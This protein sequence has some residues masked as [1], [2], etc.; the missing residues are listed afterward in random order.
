MNTLFDILPEEIIN[1]IYK[2]VN[3]D[4]LYKVY[5]LPNTERLEINYSENEMIN[6]IENIPIYGHSF[7]KDRINPHN[8]FRL[9]GD[10]CEKKTMEYANTIVPKGCDGLPMKITTKSG[11]TYLYM[12]TTQINSGGKVDREYPYTIE[13]IIKYRVLNGGCLEFKKLLKYKECNVKMV[14]NLKFTTCHTDELHSKENME[15]IN[16]RIRELHALHLEVY[17]LMNK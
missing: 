14:S 13:L 6:I 11:Q 10:K 4:T 9:P 17:E 1:L 8:M 3:Q 5:H 15:N 12:N 16:N 7:K 2:F